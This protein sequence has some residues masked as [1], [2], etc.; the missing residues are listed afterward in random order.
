MTGQRFGHDLAEKASGS[1]FDA[2]GADDD[3]RAGLG[4]QRGELFQ[5]AAQRLRR[6]DGEEDVGLR[7]CCEIGG[8]RDI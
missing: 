6:N 3:R 7:G 5:H 1:M 2:L 8:R 4:D